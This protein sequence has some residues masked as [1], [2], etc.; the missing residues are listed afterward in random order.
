MSLGLWVAI[1]ITGAVVELRLAN[2]ARYDATDDARTIDRAMRLTIALCLG[3]PLM[4][5]QS[6]PPAVVAVGASCAVV[7]VLIR[8]WAIRTLGRRY[9]LTPQ[10]QRA[11]H[12]LC[13]TGPYHYV[14]HPGYLG[15]LLQFVGMG[16]ML[17]PAAAALSA[18]PMAVVFVLRI[19]G[20]ERILVHEFAGTYRDYRR[21][22]RWKL[23]PC[24]Y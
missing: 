15:L 5:M 22:V 4:T 16:V 9:T 10:A 7:G 17:S 20:E 21:Q 1:A 24:L 14:R 8:A 2:R 12:Y 13:S 11:D 3:V 6:P 19:F 18:V 23:L